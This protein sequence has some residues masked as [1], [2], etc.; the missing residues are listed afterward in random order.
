MFLNLCFLETKEKEHEKSPN[1]AVGESHCSS[2]GNLSTELSIRHWVPQAEVN[3]L[4]LFLISISFPQLGMRLGLLSDL[5]QKES[6]FICLPSGNSELP[7]LNTQFF[8]MKVQLRH[9]DEPYCAFI[10]QITSCRSLAC[11]CSRSHYIWSTNFEELIRFWVILQ[12]YSLPFY[13][14]SWL[15][16]NDHGL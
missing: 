16:N 10:W 1:F 8:I 7:F 9:C 4:E 12:L 6:V 13:H 15:I 11:I 3:S 14:F 2:N 5:L